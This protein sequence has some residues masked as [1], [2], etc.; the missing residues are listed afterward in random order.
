MRQAAAGAAH[1]DTITA[2]HHRDRTNRAMLAKPTTASA[3]G[4]RLVR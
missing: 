4:A 1:G 2:M 3:A